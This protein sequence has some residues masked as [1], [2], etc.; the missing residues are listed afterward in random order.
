MQKLGKLFLF[1]VGCELVGLLGAVFTFSSIPTWY[2][3]LNKPIFA[4]PNNVFGPIWTTLYLLMGTAF[5]IIWEYKGKVSTKKAK[6]YFY[7]QLFLNFIWTPAFFGLKSPAL[8]LVIIVPMLFFIY[9]TIREFEKINKLAA[10]LMSPY[11][12]WVSAATI[13]NLSILLLN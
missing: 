10:F 8:G 5:F 2:Q 13:L 7:I 9:K 6:N 12:A 3:A 4:P 1:I 11:L